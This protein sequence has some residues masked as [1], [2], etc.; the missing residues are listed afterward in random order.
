[1]PHIDE[2]FPSKY[3]RASDLRNK[4]ARVVISNLVYETID[5]KRKLIMFFQGKEKGLVLNKTN[6]TA[7]AT[8]YGQDTDDWIGGELE[9]Y[10]T[11]VDYQGKQVEALR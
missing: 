11:M 5:N 1:M 8:V 4:P 10:P 3:V 7:I 6:A 2:A 9:L